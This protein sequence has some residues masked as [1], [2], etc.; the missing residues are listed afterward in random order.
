MATRDPL[1]WLLGGVGLLAL[2]VTTVA[3]TTKKKRWQTTAD[4]LKRL[5]LLEP[6]TR[7]KLEQLAAVLLS[8][9]IR[10]Y[11]GRSYATPE[12]QKKQIDAGRSGV[13]T[14]SWHQSRRAID[15]Y[16]IDPKTEKPD[17]SVANTESMLRVVH[18]EWFKLGGHGLAYKPYPSGAR[19]HIKNA[20][21]Q[22]VWDSGH[23]EFHGTFKT[24]LAAYEDAKKKGSVA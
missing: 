15:V 24:A 17:Y 6:Q 11:W 14:V 23:L 4:E 5:A 19:H 9:G 13:V 7:A 21:G 20:K 2:G 1:P 10:L 18:H 8:K 12:E 16:V 3:T 22:P